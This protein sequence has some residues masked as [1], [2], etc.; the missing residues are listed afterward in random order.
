MMKFLIDIIFNITTVF[1]CSE[2]NIYS[3]SI[4]KLNTSLL[5]IDKWFL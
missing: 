4:Q 5:P 2:V 3:F 1:F